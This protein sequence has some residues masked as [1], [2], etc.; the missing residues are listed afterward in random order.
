MTTFALTD[1]TTWVN[2]YDFTTDLN[3]I[4]LSVTADELDN[5]TFGGGGFRSRIS[6]LKTVG[7]TLNGYWQSAASAAPDPQAFPDLGVADRVVTVAPDDAA[8]TTCYMFQGGKFSYEM[9]G[10][11]GEVTPFTLG[12]SGT[13]GVGVVRGQVARPKATVNSTGATG[14]VVELG[15]VGSTQ[16]LY[17][18]LHVFTAGTT[19]T[20]Q[21][22]SDDNSGFSS[23]TTR[24]TFSGVTTVGGSWLTR[25][26]G[27][28]T[29]TYYRL[30]VSA[31]TGSFSIAGAIGI[32]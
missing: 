5:T 25:V 2:G 1:A 23:A 19:I 31:V 21:V 11:V 27:P 10:Q 8:G 20:V 13:N 3:Q 17:A 26:A 16:Y 22:Q 29:D 18:S 7:A 14:S 12:M 28:I 32:G 15:A 9:F 24:G 6:G 30:N 4:Q